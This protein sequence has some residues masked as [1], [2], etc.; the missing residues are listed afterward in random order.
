MFDM[1]VAEKWMKDKAGHIN[2][3][4]QKL[5]ELAGVD[6]YNV[7]INDR[8]KDQAIADVDDAT[9]RQIKA[10]DGSNP[11]ITLDSTYNIA[12]FKKVMEDLILPILQKKLDTEFLDSLKLESVITPFGL[13]GS[14]IVSMHSLQELNT[15]TSLEQ[16][17]KLLNSFDSL[18]S[19]DELKG[20]IKNNVGAELKIRD[21]FF[22]YNLIVHQE[23]YGNK[24]LTPI[25]I[26]YM[27]E[28]NSLGYEY[29]KYYAEVDKG[30]IDLYEDLKI[31]Y[32]EK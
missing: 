21:L 24:K 18:D 1:M 31:K 25:L 20:L 28:R 5:M 13:N 6:E 3:N 27:K 9:V 12:M 11:T 8:I 29:M 30:S 10:K 4:I 32:G 15:H 22:L 17:E 14:A 19:E 16:F 2:L 26:N 23:K 7:Y